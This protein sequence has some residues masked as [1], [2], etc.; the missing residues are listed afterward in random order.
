MLCGLGD[1][2]TMKLQIEISRRVSLA[3]AKGSDIAKDNPLGLVNDSA[4][5]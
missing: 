1:E 3:A 2:I 5:V 4:S